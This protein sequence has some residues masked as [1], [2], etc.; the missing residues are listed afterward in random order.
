[1]FYS[2][3]RLSRRFEAQPSERCCRPRWRPKPRCRGTAR[4]ARRWRWRSQRRRFRPWRAK[5]SGMC[6][7]CPCAL[8]CKRI[9]SE[10]PHRI[11]ILKELKLKIL[12]TKVPKAMQRAA[13][14][15]QNWTAACR[16]NY[17]KC[18]TSSASSW[19]ALMQSAP[20][21]SKT[22][23]TR[24]GLAAVEGRTEC[25][26][27]DGSLVEAI[28]GVRDRSGSLREIRGA[29][30]MGRRGCLWFRGDQC[31]PRKSHVAVWSKRHGFREDCPMPPTHEAKLRCDP[32][33]K[34][35]GE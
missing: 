2:L 1:M 31:L 6:L 28:E 33:L 34:P 12:D 29:V 18:R 32:A 13:R 14:D 10:K 21:W 17:K 22:S 25:R 4:R 30:A 19:R 3:Q 26:T 16:R 9:Q 35:V 20:A 23:G 11:T 24:P 15:F 5:S 7:P 8:I 27:C